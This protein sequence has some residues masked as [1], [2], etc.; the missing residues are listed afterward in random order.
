MVLGAVAALSLVRFFNNNPGS[1]SS[2]NGDRHEEGEVVVPVVVVPPPARLKA[3]GERVTLALGSGLAGAT[4]IPYVCV[5][6]DWWPATKCDWGACTW[7][8]ASVT[9]LDL[10]PGAADRRDLGSALAMLAPAALRVGGSLQDLVAYDAGEEGKLLPDDPD[11]GRCGDFSVNENDRI[12]FAGGCLAHH[13]YDDIDDLAR[14]SGAP[15]IFGLS[16]LHGR[17]RQPDIAGCSK[18]ASAPCEPCWT[19][20][21]RPRVGGSRDLLRHAA[22][23]AARNLSA[24][25]AV[26]LGNELCGAGGIAA[27]L[28]A[29]TVGGDFVQL[30]KELA[31]IWKIKSIPSERRRRRLELPPTRSRPMVGPDCQLP[32]DA[33]EN[34]NSRFFASG[35]DVVDAFTFHLYWLGSGKNARQ[36]RRKLVDRDR[37]DEVDDDIQTWPSHRGFHQRVSAYDRVAT[38][39]APEAQ[40]WVSEAGGAY[41]SGAGNVT[42]RYVSAF[43]YL[44]EL[45]ALAERSIALH[46]RQALVGGHYAL[47]RRHLGRLEPNPD[48]F[49]TRLWATLMGARVVRARLLARQQNAARDASAY[50]HCRLAT[51][52]ADGFGDLVVLVINSS[53]RRAIQIQ[54]PGKLATASRDEFHVTAPAAPDGRPDLDAR[55]ALLNGRPSFPA[56]FLIQNFVNRIF[57][58]ARRLVAVDQPLDPL[59]A[60]PQ[61]R[62]I[63]DPASYAFFVFRRLEWP[64]CVA[65]SS[66]LYF[67]T[68]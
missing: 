48:Y 66:D 55:L 51:R 53:S 2:K 68:R 4:S 60:K 14:E 35:G 61:E 8:R 32:L 38:A 59:H 41:G 47:L 5:T 17:A 26:S 56:A 29:E 37:L 18:C 11:F 44:D 42:D 1:S 12:G 40:V 33:I 31:R 52:G 15:L 45:G 7:A 21:W 24:L 50:A 58:R 39:G 49:A 19:G 27:H 10:R 54:P 65:S 9:S 67:D 20:V 62:L 6:I 34:W 36:T 25:A 13:R 43:W 63:V 23:R 22:D 3:R 46:C 16:G 30:D 64:A 57:T 28:S